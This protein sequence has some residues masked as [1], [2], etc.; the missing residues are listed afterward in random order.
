LKRDPADLAA[1]I[2][3][4]IT[5]TIVCPTSPSTT[6]FARRGMSAIQSDNRMLARPWE[7]RPGYAVESADKIPAIEYGVHVD[8]RHQRSKNHI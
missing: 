3:V 2:D 4:L 7:Q 6:R 1:I 5:E 8:R